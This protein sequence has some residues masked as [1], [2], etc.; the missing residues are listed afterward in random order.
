[1]E[2]K[3]ITAEMLR[4]LFTLFLFDSRLYSWKNVALPG[5]IA[6]AMRSFL[7]LFFCVG[8]Y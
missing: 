2:S 1:M 5:I 4:Y 6:I 8:A 7:P 3:L